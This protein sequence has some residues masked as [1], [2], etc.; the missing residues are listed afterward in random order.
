MD[1]LVFMF[2]TAHVAHNTSTTPLTLPG[3]PGSRSVSET[4]SWSRTL[5]TVSWSPSDYSTP[6]SSCTR[7]CEYTPA[8]GTPWSDYLLYTDLL[9]S[10]LLPGLFILV[11]NTMLIHRLRKLAR[12][13]QALTSTPKGSDR[14]SQ[15][16]TVMLVAVSV[17]F[18]V[19]ACPLT[20]YILS[21]RVIW[22]GVEQE[23]PE[24]LGIVSA[25]VTLFYYLN[26]SLNFFFYFLTGPVFRQAFIQRFCCKK[27]KPVLN[28][29]PSFK[30]RSL[31]YNVQKKEQSPAGTKS[32]TTI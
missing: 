17:L 25:T 6:P 3:P 23:Q 4:S 2:P 26:H 10:C 7:K 31:T 32:T 8:G 21:C 20:L 27:T 9:L 18:L 14:R 28:L 11:A 13:R 24:W 30:R 16:L 22:V 5:P 1:I 29:A 12:R 15:S 19:T